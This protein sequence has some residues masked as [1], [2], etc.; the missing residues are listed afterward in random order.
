MTAGGCADARISLGAY[1]LGAL[2]PAERG[3]VD[4]HLADCDA[5]RD[6]L[7]SFAALPGLLSRVSLDEV[8]SDVASDPHPHLLERILDATVRERRRARR[9]RWVSAAAAAVILV[10]GAGA[11]GFAVSQPHQATPTATFSGTSS[12]TGLSASV[13]EWSKGWGSALKV[14]LTGAGGLSYS[15]PTCQLVAVSKSGQQDVAATWAATASDKIVAEGSTSLAPS[16]IASFKIVD[17]HGKE[18]VSIP[19]NT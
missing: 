6:E 4:A 7:A 8:E 15:T 11:T 14:E 17:A 10:G 12:T 9:V 5:C 1:V 13:V 2:E 16:D 18:L 3:R 19:A